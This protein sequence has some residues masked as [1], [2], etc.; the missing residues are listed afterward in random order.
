[1]SML[2]SNHKPFQ[3]DWETHV[4]DSRQLHCPQCNQDSP[5][6]HTLCHSLAHIGVKR[7]HILDQWNQA[8]TAFFDLIVLEKTYWCFKILLSTL[9][10]CSGLLSECCSPLFPT[11]PVCPKQVQKM[12]RKQKSEFGSKVGH[13]P[14]LPSGQENDLTE[15]KR[16]DRVLLCVPS[17]ILSL[18]EV[19]NHCLTCSPFQGSIVF[20]VCCDSFACV[21]FFSWRELSEESFSDSHGLDKML[22]DWLHV[23]L[24]PRRSLKN[25]HRML[26]CWI[27]PSP[28]T[29][30]KMIQ[31][32]LHPNQEP[33]ICAFF[34]DVRLLQSW[35]NI[36]CFHLFSQVC[37]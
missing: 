4:V 37:F 31:L 36:R 25:T 1:M 34:L 14:I 17:S 30:V 21:L 23:F 11:F 18:V 8:F 35:V 29:V 12:P 26:L 33:S 27:V 22:S 32:I 13:A 24:S 7:D 19:E 10:L 6:F 5:G 16:R 2:H 20:P 28:L 9:S 15:S 3:W